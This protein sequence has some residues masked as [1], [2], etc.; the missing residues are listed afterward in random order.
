M[1]FNTDLLHSG[2]VMEEKGATLP[3]IYQ[4][5]AFE[6]ATASDLANIFE[7]KKAG[8]C[9][10]R[11]GNPTVTAFDR[12]PLGVYQ[13]FSWKYADTFFFNPVVSGRMI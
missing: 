13:I 8:Y 7:N 12:M 3:P 4:S 1:G 6:Q 9:Y 10:T 11:V 2:V 5:S